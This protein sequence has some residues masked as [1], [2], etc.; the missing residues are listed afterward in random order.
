MIKERRDKRERAHTRRTKTQLLL[1][2]FLSRHRIASSRSLPPLRV[3]WWWW[4]W[5]WFKTV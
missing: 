2:L 5:W 4:W 3:K 1:S